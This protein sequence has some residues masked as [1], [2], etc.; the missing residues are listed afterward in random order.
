MK[1]HAL[2]T[3]GVTHAVSAG[4]QVL[5][6][7]DACFAPETAGH[8]VL[9]RTPARD[10]S[11]RTHVIVLIMSRLNCVMKMKLCTLHIRKITTTKEMLRF[12]ESI[13][14]YAV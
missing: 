12:E 5:V 13:P 10:V 14:Y 9:R 8:R 1:F 4:H 2:Q 3:S 11:L 7:R 6:F